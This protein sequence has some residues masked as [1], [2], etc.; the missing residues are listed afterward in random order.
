M[1]TE[2][3]MFDLILKVAKEDERIRAVYMNGSR[4]NPNAPVDIFQDYDIV[5][6]VKEIRSFIDDRNWIDIFGERLYMQCPD[7]LD[8]I[9]GHIDEIKNYYGWLIQ[10]ADG[11]RLDLH[12]QTIDVA[13]N[14]ILN[15]KLCK[16]L[17]DKDDILPFIP[18]AT[19]QDYYVKKPSNE[20][21][22]CVCNEFWWCLNNVAKGLWREEVPY[23][24]DMINY[25]V[26][27]Q[28]VKVL[29]WKIGIETNYSCSIGKSGK[30]MYRW[31][32]KEIW[33]LFLKTYS[34]GNVIEIWEAVLT[35]CNL[36]DVVAHEVSKKLFYNYYENEANE[37]L[38]FLKHTRQLSKS[39]KE[40]Y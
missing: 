35:M 15:D 26:R 3:E 24:Q 19:D 37:S 11:N 7:E 12:V 32:P 18:E 5:F 39:A 14:D 1:R 2:H 28:L 13:K 40:I 25:F 34:S 17:L 16:I 9:L 6:V 30:Y 23:V 4:T 10:L 38:K 31:L 8:L 36:F 33:E 20:E 22:G 29:S 27:P 21:F